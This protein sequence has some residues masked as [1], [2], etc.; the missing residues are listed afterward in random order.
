M[1]QE[2]TYLLPDLIPHSPAEP[3]NT[4]QAIASSVA[5]ALTIPYL[6]LDP[7]EVHEHDAKLRAAGIAP[8]HLYQ[9][10]RSWPSMQWLS[11]SHNQQM[12]GSRSS[13][14]SQVPSWQPA[15]LS[16]QGVVPAQGVAAASLGIQPQM[17][18]AC[19]WQQPQRQQA[20]QVSVNPSSSFLQS[21]CPQTAAYPLQGTAMSAGLRE[22][23]GQHQSAFNTQLQAIL[24][25][26]HGQPSSAQGSHQGPG[27]GTYM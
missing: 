27:Q 14:S 22:V 16:W 19:S 21:I 13:A 17:V 6:P 8:M 4:D 15:M 5:S 10:P 12:L 18:A 9:E 23:P 3:W 2:A 26:A 1:L 24:G 11:Q 20:Q 25:S 7:K